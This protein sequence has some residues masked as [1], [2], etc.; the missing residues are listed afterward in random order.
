MFG[1]ANIRKEIV[2]I[3][4]KLKGNKL[5]KVYHYIYESFNNYNHIQ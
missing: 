3:I 4:L 1:L 2:I 5:V